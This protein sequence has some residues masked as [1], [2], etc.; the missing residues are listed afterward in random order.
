MDAVPVKDPLSEVNGWRR[1]GGRRID[2]VATA[3]EL[4]EV[5]DCG[6][7]FGEGPW[8][9]TGSDFVRQDSGGMGAWVPFQVDSTELT[10]W[11]A[12]SPAHRFNVMVWSAQYTSGLPRATPSSRYDQLCGWSGFITVQ[13]QPTPPSPGCVQASF[14]LVDQLRREDT[15]H[16]RTYPEYRRV[17]ER[18]RRDVL[19]RTA[20]ANHSSTRP[21]AVGERWT[22]AASLARATDSGGASTP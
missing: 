18:L 22:Q 4:Q 20:T 15:G 3:V 16:L 6:L 14:T 1:V 19:R 2:F 21:G 7:H 10:V 8:G 11:D 12:G 13:R 5:L 9:A 17:F